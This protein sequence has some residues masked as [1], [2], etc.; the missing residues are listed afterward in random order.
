MLLNRIINKLIQIKIIDSIFVMFNKKVILFWSHG[1]K[2]DKNF[3]DTINSILFELITKKEVVNSSN[4]ANFSKHKIY[5][6]IGSIMDN[7]NKSNVMS[8]G[9]G[10]QN[11]NAQRKIQ[12]QNTF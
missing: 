12:C 10:F 4:I 6:V 8:C 11:E 1:E 7:L 3:G 2:K 5:Y 9:I